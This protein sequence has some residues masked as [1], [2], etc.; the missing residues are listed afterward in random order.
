[1]FLTLGKKFGKHKPL[2]GS[3]RVR[4]ITQLTF[5]ETVFSQWPAVLKSPTPLKLSQLWASLSIIEHPSSLSSLRAV[6]DLWSPQSWECL[7]LVGY[8]LL[9][10]KRSR[11]SALDAAR[12]VGQNR[13]CTKLLL[14]LSVS[15]G[16]WKAHCLA[17]MFSINFK[18]SWVAL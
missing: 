7:R 15:K 10:M 9:S 17:E 13:L 2:A 6:S 14:R 11:S 8:V 5:L 18:L 16:A 3:T 4:Y 12:L 1:M